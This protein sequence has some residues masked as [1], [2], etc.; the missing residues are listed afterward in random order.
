M[1]IQKRIKLKNGIEFDAY[2]RIDGMHGNKNELALQVNA[3]N[4]LDGNKI[5]VSILNPEIGNI[6]PVEKQIRKP[7]YS[8]IPNFENN[9]N[10]MAQGYNYLKTLPEF[11]GAVN[12]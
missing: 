1:A 8:F 10:F 6:S 5:F 3:Y 9:D 12:I 11:I 4:I 7:F 2:I